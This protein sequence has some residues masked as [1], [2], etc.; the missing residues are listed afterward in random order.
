MGWWTGSPFAVVPGATQAAL[1][2][3]ACLPLLGL[4]IVMQRVVF[5]GVTLS[6]V[7]A[8]GVA[9]GLLL[10]LPPLPLGLALCG[11]MVAGLARRVQG[12][13]GAGGDSALGAAFC[14]ASA[15]ALLFIS[16]SP[17]DLDQVSHVLHGNL[18]FATGADVRLMGGALLGGTLLIGLCFQR[19]LFCAFD[20]ETAAALGLPVRRWLLFL[21][22]VLAVVLTLSM[23]TTGALLTFALLILPALAALQL[24]LGVRASFAAASL[25]GVVGALAGLAIAVR[26][27]LHV[28]S[29]IVVTAF[30][31]VPLARLARGSR[32]LALL[33]CAGLVGL[34]PLLAPAAA[35]P[36]GVHADADAAEHPAILVDVH[37]AARRDAAAPGRVLVEWTLAVRGADQD[38]LPDALWLIVTGDGLL[39]EQVLVADTH[40]LERGSARANG[41]FTLEQ[42]TG[43]RRLEGQLWSGPSGAL[44]ALP[45]DGGVVIGCPVR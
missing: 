36:D 4:W 45:V 1:L 30:L 10:H 40:A 33:A 7:A 18:L 16:R 5:L 26:A 39:A 42:A 34:V 25:L 23:Q 29:A 32:L 28:E 22:S 31:L 37:L 12:G 41:R 9:L 43:A 13:I 21:F 19:I 17:A 38:Q 14:L 2:A 35:P 8:A 6:Q 11:L 44:D 3:G 20:G 15:L 24:R 27:D